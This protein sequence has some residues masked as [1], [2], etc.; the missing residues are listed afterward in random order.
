MAVIRGLEHLPYDR[1]RKLGL[2]RPGDLSSLPARKKLSG[3]VVVIGQGVMCTNRKR[4][5][6]G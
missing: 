3:T 2:F 6:L 1:L 4:G 5:K